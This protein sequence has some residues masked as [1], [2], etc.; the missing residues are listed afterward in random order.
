MKITLDDILT[1][2]TLVIKQYGG[3]YGIRDKN[4]IESAYNVSFQGFGDVD[5]YPSVEEKAARLGFGLATNHGFVDG[6]KRTGC[7]VLLTFLKLNGLSLECSDE[8]L[9][10][11]F[12]GIAD[13]QK[14]T[15]DDLLQFVKNHVR[16]I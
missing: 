16:K 5:F 13:A 11:M 9:I 3:E 15:Y 6:N 8:E 2:H 7:I 1:L 4:V 14:N 12:Y 10:T